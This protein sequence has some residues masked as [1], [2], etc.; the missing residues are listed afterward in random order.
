[1]HYHWNAFS[2][3]G[4]ATITP[5]KAGVQLIP[6]EFKNSLTGIDIAEVRDYYKCK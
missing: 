2:K 5:K 4:L 3:N 6:T 1:M